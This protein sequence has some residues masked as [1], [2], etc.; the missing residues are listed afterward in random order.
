MEGFLGIK[1][2]DIGYRHHQ[3]QGDSFQRLRFKNK[4]GKKVKLHSSCMM[5]IGGTGELIVV[6]NG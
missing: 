3:E 2:Q 1:R 4:M 5:E 6:R